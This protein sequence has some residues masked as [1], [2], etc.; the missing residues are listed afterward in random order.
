MFEF[1][2]LSNLTFDELIFFVQEYQYLI[3]ILTPLLIGEISIHIFGVLNGSGD[4]SL[5]PF[6]ISVIST[7]V[8]DVAVYYIAQML[9]R[10]GN[11][12]EKIRKIKILS[13]LERIFRKCEKRYDK[14]PILLLAAIKIMPMT[15]FTLLFFALCSKISAARFVF[16]SVIV[17]AIWAVVVFLPGWF[18]GKEFLTQD[19]GRE[20]SNVILYFLLLM[21]L[22]ILF[23]EQIDRMTI[24]VINKITA[25]LDRR[26]E[27]KKKSK[28]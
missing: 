14:Y 11:T 3:S 28:H 4:I 23:N 25:I 18:V 26:A 2:T 22:L 15:K 19:A 8:F 7:V 13:G 9:K 16:N 10:S 17:N 5:L 21:I 20:V 12:A 27:K 6:I 24:S 1:F